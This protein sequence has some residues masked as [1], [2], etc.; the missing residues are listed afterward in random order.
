MIINPILYAAIMMVWYVT[1]PG[2]LLI[3]SVSEIVN[4]L[5][6]VLAADACLLI[7]CCL[8]AVIIGHLT[9]WSPDY[10]M[11]NHSINTH[12]G[13]YQHQSFLNYVLVSSTTEVRIFGVSIPC[14]K[15]CTVLLKPL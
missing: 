14:Y 2:S 4:V 13:R 6:L 8:G 15:K 9:H 3:S 1:F 7:F 10:K 11:W 5:S 12:T